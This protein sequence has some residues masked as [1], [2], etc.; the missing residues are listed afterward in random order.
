M[1]VVS[2]RSSGCITLAQDENREE[3]AENPARQ[4]GAEGAGGAS[5]A[6]GYLAKAVAGLF[7]NQRDVQAEALAFLMG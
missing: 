2:L 5:G 1:C 7:W 6:T 4:M 3:E